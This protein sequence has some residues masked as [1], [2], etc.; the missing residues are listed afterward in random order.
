MSTGVDPVVGG[1]ERSEKVSL[2]QKT[3]DTVNAMSP[4]N[5]T[6][7]TTTAQVKPTLAVTWNTTNLG[8]RLAADGAAAA[9]AGVL[10]APIITM[11]DQYVYSSTYAHQS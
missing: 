4:T 3:K 11:I 7:T 8:L 2:V 10:V 9:T 5:A 1:A 6:A